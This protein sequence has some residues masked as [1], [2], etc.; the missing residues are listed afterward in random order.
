MVQD[1]PTAEQDSDQS[2]F[3]GNP[4][5]EIDTVFEPEKKGVPGVWG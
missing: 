2:I 5:E 1:F 3:T 4:K